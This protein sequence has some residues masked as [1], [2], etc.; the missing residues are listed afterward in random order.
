MLDLWSLQ[1]HREMFDLVQCYKIINNIS[2]V[3]VSFEMTGDRERTSLVTRNKSDP[4]NLVKP[5]VNL[6]VRRN[7][8]TVRIVNSSN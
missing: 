1:K 6:E 7:F 8:F 2:N 3:E 4:R 5:K